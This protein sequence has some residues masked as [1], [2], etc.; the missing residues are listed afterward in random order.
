[1]KFVEQEDRH[2]S[3]IRERIQELKS[4]ESR[5]NRE[6][7]ELRKLKDRNIINLEDDMEKKRVSYE[8]NIN[9]LKVTIEDLKAANLQKA[10]EILSL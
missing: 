2:S 1:M 6:M 7:E 9:S 3:E 4:T 5:L 8:T 10:S